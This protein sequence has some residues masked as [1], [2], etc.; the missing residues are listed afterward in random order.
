M[1]TANLPMTPVCLTWAYD[2]RN[3]NRREV[4]TVLYYIIACS[5]IFTTIHCEVSESQAHSEK[6]NNMLCGTGAKNSS[7][8]TVPDEQFVLI[9]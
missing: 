4:E 8:Q 9:C 5:T 7:R 6:V 1:V 2:V 3:A